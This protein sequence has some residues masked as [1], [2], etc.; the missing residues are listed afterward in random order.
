MGEETHRLRS[1]SV[2]MAGEMVPWKR[3]ARRSA[4][5]A[6]ITMY[7]AIVALWVSMQ[8]AVL[9]WRSDQLKQNLSSMVQT[10]K[11]SVL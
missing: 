9:G 8:N 5:T 7:E 3:S 2:R 10:A 6:A 4:P 11:K 1:S